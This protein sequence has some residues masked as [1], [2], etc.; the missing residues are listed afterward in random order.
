MP[1]CTCKFV[2]CLVATEI[3]RNKL[4]TCSNHITVIKYFSQ[5][6]EKCEVL[7]FYTLVQFINSS[8]K[9]SLQSYDSKRKHSLAYRNRT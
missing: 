4:I 5:N 7:Y 2:E 9:W 8:V 3:E 1:N 6:K